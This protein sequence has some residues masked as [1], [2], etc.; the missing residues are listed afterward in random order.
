[1]KFNF[2]IKKDEIKKGL[3]NLSKIL[4]KKSI[5]K[6]AAKKSSDVV[7]SVRDENKKVLYSWL[8]AGKELNKSKSKFNDINLSLK[9]VPSNKIKALKSLLKGKNG[10]VVSFAHKGK[11]PAAA[12]IKIY[13]AKKFNYAKN[14]KLYVYYYNEKKNRLEE[15]N[16]N[17]GKV[18]KKGVLE[19]KTVRGADYVVLSEKLDKN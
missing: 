6:E 12:T 17:G 9:V 15:T 18:L 10:T 8:I 7:I 3:A 1:M 13:D 19:F 16:Y 5:L 11:L 14:K 4:V 2:N